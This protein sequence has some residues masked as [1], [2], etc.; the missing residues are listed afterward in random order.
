M[1]FEI[2]ISDQASND[3]KNIY[4]YIGFEL[5]SP[6]NAKGQ[7]ERLEKGI[8]GL[9]QLP[10]RFRKYDKEPWYSRGLH[11]RPIDNYCILYILDLDKLLVTIIRVMYG[12][13][14]IEMQLEKCTKI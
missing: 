5:Q 14:D 13:Q 9:E 7:L 6:E 3:L 1:T 10:E 4:E 12:G 8:F 11:I 2:E